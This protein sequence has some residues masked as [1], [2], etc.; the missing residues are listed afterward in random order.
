M[1][2]TDS[3]TIWQIMIDGRPTVGDKFCTYSGRVSHDAI[4]AY[5]REHP[6]IDPVKVGAR[7]WRSDYA[8]RPIFRL[9]NGLPETH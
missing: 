2:V 9:I 7:Y 4:R 1:W 8:E 3:I 5:C 6:D